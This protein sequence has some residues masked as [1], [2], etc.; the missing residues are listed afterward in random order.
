MGKITGRRGP[1]P[2]TL[3]KGAMVQVGS[4][5]RVQ[6]HF[7]RGDILE[8]EETNPEKLSLKKTGG[9]DE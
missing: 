6:T 3:H 9:G 5:R 8:V 7:N 2:Q 4:N 1:D